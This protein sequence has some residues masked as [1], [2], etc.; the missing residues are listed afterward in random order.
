MAIQT[1]LVQ[2]VLAK[3]IRENPALHYT[4]KKEGKTL[5]IVFLQLNS[6]I[7]LRERFPW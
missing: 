3:H 7:M 1:L 6:M 2:T 5:P 4:K